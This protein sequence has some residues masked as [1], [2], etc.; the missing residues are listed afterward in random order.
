MDAFDWFGMA[1]REVIAASVHLRRV[2]ERI[3]AG[4]CI[5]C[6]EKLKVKP[7]RGCCR[8]C[9]NLFDVELNRLAPT[10]R[11]AAEIRKIRQGLI[12]GGK[13]GVRSDLSEAAG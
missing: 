5:R 13:Q 3:A 4:K 9:R 2:R 8:R 1:A 7:R 10:R 11:H 12:L 6:G